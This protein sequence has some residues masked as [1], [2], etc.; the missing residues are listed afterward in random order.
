MEAR[1][2][3]AAN[4]LLERL[5]GVLLDELK[6]AEADAL[7][8]AHLQRASQGDRPYADFLLDL[9]EAEARAR[10]EERFG[11]ALKRSRLPVMK[12]LDQFDFAFQPRIDQSQVRELRT[13][14]A[15]CM[16][17]GT[18]CSWGRRAWAKHTWPLR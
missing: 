10:Q 14:R 8:E 7:V 9:L 11:Q 2:C 1:C 5:H 18:S 4:S 12:T 3:M 17:P 13:L 15:S 16:R 6:M